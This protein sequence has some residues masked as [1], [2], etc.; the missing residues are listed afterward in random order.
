[1]RHSLRLALA[2]EVARLRA[3]GTTVV[4]FEPDARDQ[5]VMAGNPLDPAK[6]EPVCRQVLETTRRRLHRAST[7]ARLAALG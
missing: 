5:E 7:R 3:G 2:A 1:M 6:R 4:T